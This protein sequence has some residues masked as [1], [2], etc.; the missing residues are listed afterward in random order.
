[1]KAILARI[2]FL[3]EIVLVLVIRRSTLEIKILTETQ[4][5]ETKE[6]QEIKIMIEIPRTKVM[7]TIQEIKIMKDIL[8]TRIKIEILD[9]PI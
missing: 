8:G 7:V 4:R 2:R 5:V 3:I 9:P 6:T 1:L